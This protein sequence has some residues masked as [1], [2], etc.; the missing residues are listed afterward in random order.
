MGPGR[1][2]IVNADDYGLSPGVSLGIREAHRQGIVTTT[3]AMMNRPGIGAEL[4]L[5]ARECPRLGVG[6]HLLLTSGRSLRPVSE[7]PTLVAPDGWF[8][9]IGDWP[10]LYAGVKAEQLVGEWRRQV[11]TFLSL[12]FPLRLSL[13]H[14]DSHHHIAYRHPGMLEALLTLAREYDV[15]VRYPGPPPGGNFGTAETD[16]G[17]TLGSRSWAGVRHPAGMIGSFFGGTATLD[18][19]LKILK[20]LPAAPVELMC[21]PAR[22][23]IDPDFA[24]LTSYNAPREREREVLTDPRVREAITSHGITLATFAEACP[25]RVARRM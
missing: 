10:R 13:D 19:L 5:A 15:P 25:A 16:I 7:V 18:N 14:L 4:R 22:A 9:K 3:T 20:S 1:T 11:E 24:A 23:D 17:R 2:L 21:H 6:V 12:A 8:P